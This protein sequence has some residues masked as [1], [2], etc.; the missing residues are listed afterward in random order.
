MA[1]EAGTIRSL[2]DRFRHAP[3]MS[4]EARHSGDSL[5]GSGGE[6]A[7]PLPS[8]ASSEAAAAAVPAAMAAPESFRT[9]S[10]WG[11]VAA[12]PSATSAAAAISQSAVAPA[13]AAPASATPAPSVARQPA[14]AD[15]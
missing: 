13:V 14:S 11:G 8:W 2:I 15:P 7:Q 6:A 3:P 5:H 1:L 10:R 9:R 12:A 4:R